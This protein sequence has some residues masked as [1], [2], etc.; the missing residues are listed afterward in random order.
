[1]KY[2]E[3]G[4]IKRWQGYARTVCTVAIELGGVL[5]KAGPFVSPRND[6]QPPGVT[7]HLADLRDEA[8]HVPVYEHRSIIEEDLGPIALRFAQFEDKAVAAASLGQ[9]HRARLHNG[10]RVVVK[11]LRPGIVE[12]CHTDLAAVNVVAHFAM[13]FRFISRRADAVALM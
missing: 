13:R 6:I 3:R 2:D 1:P 4:D 8:P 7:S 9:V 5:I 10:D 12:V 11:V